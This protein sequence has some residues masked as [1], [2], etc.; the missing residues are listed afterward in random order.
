MVNASTQTKT[1]TFF[2]LERPDWLIAAGLSKGT[3]HD[4][5]DLGAILLPGSKVR[6]R[7]VFPALEAGM[8]LHLLNDD[9]K[10]EQHLVIGTQWN[11]LTASAASVPFITTLYSDRA[12][13]RI[14]F[15]V[16]FEG[17][18]KSLPIYQRGS[19]TIMFFYNW[20]AWSAEY[21]LVAS[22]YA[23]I[24][25][26]AKDKAVVKSLRE[27][28]GLVRLLDY[29]NQVFEYFNQLTGLSFET[30]VPTDKNIPNRYFMKADKSGAGAA[31]YGGAWTAQTSDSVA[32]FWLD[33]RPEN[34]GALH[35][36]SH[37][38][39]GKFFR[40]EVITITETWTNVLCQFYQ[41]KWMGE[42][43]YKRG[44]LYGGGEEQLYANTRRIFDLGMSSAG[45]VGGPVLL[46]YLLNI[47]RMGERAL[48]EFYQ[49]YR[50][51]SNTSDFRVE[52][53]PAMDLLAS[54]GIDVANI[55]VS[56][57]ME[58]VK[59]Q[60]STRLA[61]QNAF[62]NAPLAYPLYLLL[63]EAHLE[64]VQALL[65]L[66]SPLHL[67]TIDQLAA[68]GMVGQVQLQFD[69]DIFASVSGKVL[70]LKDGLGKSLIFKITRQLLVIGPLPIGAYRLQLPAAVDGDYQS[71][72][73][74]ISVSSALT[75]VHLAYVKKYA[76]ALADQKIYLRGL[77]GVFCALTVNVSNGSLTIRLIHI[78]PHVYFNDEVYAGITVRNSQGHLVFSREILGRGNALFSQELSVASG[79]TIEILHRE[80]SRLEISG[81]LASP[82]IDTTAQINLLTM[83]AQGL[84]NAS[85]GTRAGDNL[86]VEMQETAELFERNPHWALHDDFPLKQDFKRAINTF[87]EP[88]RSQLFER[89]RALEFTPPMNDRTLAGDRMKWSLEGNAARKLGDITV[90]LN[91][92]NVR[93]AFLQATPHEYFASVY[94]S[95]MLKSDTG[96][97]RYL[98][99]FRGDVVA[100]E[101]LLTLPLNLGDTLTVMHRE[102][103]RAG[104]EVNSNGRKVPVRL[105]QHATYI[106]PGILA[107]SSYWPA[108]TRALDPQP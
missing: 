26:P 4:R 107:L 13:E 55:D 81:S 18:I 29:H 39:E 24:L 71:T 105:V 41:N 68:T 77:Q 108:A 106:A 45:G 51:I 34:W 7:Q 21:A 89:Y 50:R 40:D 36:I 28:G 103:S 65:Q 3:Y 17:P 58:Y 10:T 54:V 44:W 66:R 60:V 8:N 25:I 84:V 38:Y 102:P 76:S 75:L 97:I 98:R 1:Y 70:L 11:E 2:S 99:E 96:E 46:F 6:I 91:S 15:E 32:A 9:S 92:R 80:P 86:Q 14:E 94:L 82:V 61:M 37:G 72:N 42:E 20:D 56:A 62:S 101:E 78:D 104:I 79:F 64:Q 12:G 31:Y 73:D 49:R 35:E 43:V 87:D 27:N 16:E 57:F 88:L 5:S 22:T 95:V 63:H 74:Y 69:D 47:W 93:L 100:R 23:Q 83:T 90:D 19:N 59:V 48:V 52:N 53:Y 85:L 67:V 30:A 33:I